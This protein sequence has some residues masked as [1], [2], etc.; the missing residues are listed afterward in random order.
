MISVIG[1]AEQIG[2]ERLRSP[3]NTYALENHR[4]A[5]IAGDKCR[6]CG[7]PISQW[8]NYPSKDCEPEGENASD[9]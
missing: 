6:V 3:W 2:R 1:I 8:C 7:N 5:V 9:S 4:L